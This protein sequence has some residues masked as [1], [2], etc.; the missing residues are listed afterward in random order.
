ML[1]SIR[2]LFLISLLAF[3]GCAQAVST[4]TLR[5]HDSI[6]KTSYTTYL[7]SAGSAEKLRAVFLKSPE[8]DV[9]IVPY[10]IQIITASGT[11]Q[12]AL[13]FME[14]TAAYRRVNFQGVTY[15][16]KTIGYLLTYD[17]PI[18]ARESIEV[19]LFERNG[20]VYFSVTEK[21]FD[22]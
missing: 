10:S 18:F 15:K 12:D 19:N 8:T 2:V 6:P 20:K 17:Q 1:R 21:R 14:K 3:L 5:D 13:N 11:L 22:Y 4:F 16:G 7:Y 9:E